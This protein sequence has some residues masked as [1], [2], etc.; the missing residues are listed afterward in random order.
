MFSRKK[1]AA[2]AAGVCTLGL[3]VGAYAYFTAPG[4]GSASATVGTASGVE[5][6]GTT[7]DALYPG[8]PGIDVAISVKNPGN[9]AQ[10]VDTVTLDHLDTTAGCAA[11]AFSM[12][13]VSV[14]TTLA[15]GAS[16][17]VH[18]TLVMADSGNQD[19]C[20]GSAL[21]LHLTSN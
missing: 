15:A 12:A 8:G 4:A 5:L 1:F 2:L 3:S 6:N 17:T 7:S 16:T 9:G 14:D 13:P 20:Q 10:H 18:G 19:G 21:T 11:S